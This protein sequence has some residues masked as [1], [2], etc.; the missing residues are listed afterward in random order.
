MPGDYYDPVVYS[1][2]AGGGSLNGALTVESSLNLS[3]GL[4]PQ[5][6]WLQVGNSGQQFADIDASG[7][8]NFY[9]LLGNRGLFLRGQTTPGGTYFG[10]LNERIQT[11]T[12]FVLYNGIATAGA[13]VPAIYGLDNRTG[14]TAADATAVTLYAVPAAGGLFR[15]SGSL[16]CTAYTSG[17]GTYTLTWTDVNG[18]A[19]TRV[20]SLSAVGHADI[21]AL[22]LERVE[23]GTNITAQLTGTFVATFDTAM[24]VEQVA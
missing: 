5:V 22:G 8:T 24:V 14:L 11:S 15:I 13:G 4:P 17:T 1:D 7:N 23:G 16:D 10:L 21:N 6:R 12:A 3:S 18:T 19:H 20:A 9:P 2:G